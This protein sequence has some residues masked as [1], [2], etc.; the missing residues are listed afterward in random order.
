MIFFSFEVMD[1]AIYLKLIPLYLYDFAC[2]YNEWF[3]Y[4]GSPVPVPESYERCHLG[5]I[6]LL[7][8]MLRPLL[9]LGRS[10]AYTF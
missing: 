10:E 6:G 1:R 3:P 5:E 4:P 7:P 2:S 8:Y 9:P